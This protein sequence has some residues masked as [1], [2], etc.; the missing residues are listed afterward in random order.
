[1]FKSCEYNFQLHRKNGMRSTPRRELSLYGKLNIGKFAKCLNESLQSI[2]LFP[3][4][5]NLFS[6]ICIE[7]KDGNAYGWSQFSVSMPS[8]ILKFHFVLNTSLLT[9]KIFILKNFYLVRDKISVSECVDGTKILTIGFDAKDLGKNYHLLAR[10]FGELELLY[11]ILGITTKRNQMFRGSWYKHSNHLGTILANNSPQDYHKSLFLWKVYPNFIDKL[12]LAD[13]HYVLENLQIHRS[14]DD[15]GNA[16][17][18]REHKAILGLNVES[19]N[20]GLIDYIYD[21]VIEIYYK[22]ERRNFCLDKCFANFPMQQNSNVQELANY[23]YN[24]N[25]FIVKQRIYALIWSKHERN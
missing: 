22:Q 3:D 12:S 4:L 18:T 5:R 19:E 7:H 20:F 21:S 10:T 2:V 9:H 17:L 15:V 11:K 13:A 23:L 1:M 8:A 24:T 25:P 16:V 6:L 14:L